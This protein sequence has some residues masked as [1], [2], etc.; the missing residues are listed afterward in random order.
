MGGGGGTDIAN[1]MISKNA[2]HVLLKQVTV[3]P[4]Y[5]LTHT[6]LMIFNGRESLHVVRTHAGH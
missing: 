1:K 3:P 5:M 2:L 4:M 6:Q